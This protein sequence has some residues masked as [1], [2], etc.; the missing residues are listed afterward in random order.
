MPQVESCSGQILATELYYSHLA[1]KHVEDVRPPEAS[2][3]RTRVEQLRRLAAFA[4][5]FAQAKELGPEEHA[6]Q[7]GHGM[8]THL[9]NYVQTER[10]G[11]TEGG[12]LQVI[13]R[14]Y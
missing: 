4:F 7:Q 5:D 14:F 3:V 12:S 6:D 13:R 11:G 8:R 1:E 9:D 2:A 10:G